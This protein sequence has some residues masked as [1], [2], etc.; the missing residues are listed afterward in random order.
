MGRRPAA[1]LAGAAAASLAS[2]HSAFDDVRLASQF[3]CPP[4]TQSP[5]IRGWLGEPC[6][7]NRSSPK[8]GNRSLTSI[9]SYEVGTG[10]LQLIFF[11]PS[12]TELPE[13]R[14]AR[15]I[16]TIPIGF[17]WIS[18]PPSSDTRQFPDACAHIR[19]RADG[20]AIQ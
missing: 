12:A 17:L 6:L 11:I 7:E 14:Q 8:I 2:V 20:A 9:P 1:A 18:N 16:V 3:E 5:R 19:T 4:S 13:G 15:S 10:R